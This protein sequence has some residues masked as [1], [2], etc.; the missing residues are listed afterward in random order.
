MIFGIDGMDL[1]ITP[2]H[3]LDRADMFADEIPGDFDTMAAHIDDGP[4]ARQLF[5][6][7]PVAVW[8]RM[9][10]TRARPQ[11]RAQR[12]CGDR[13]QRFEGFGG[14]DQI[15]EVAGKHPGFLDGL[16]HAVGF[17]RRPPQWL[18]AEHSFAGLGGSQH[19]FF[20]EVIGQ[21]HYHQLGAGVGNSRRHISSG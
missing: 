12:T 14:I 6:K 2:T 1:G 7:K 20:V 18:G 17:G 13:L 15:F 3:H 4:P 8:S 10:F 11:H 9:R 16:E 21:T 5:V 19:C